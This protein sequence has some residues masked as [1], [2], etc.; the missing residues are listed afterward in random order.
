MK[1]NKIQIQSL[2]GK[3]KAVCEARRITVDASVPGDVYRDLL[4][5]GKIPD[6][7]YRDNEESLQWIGEVD[8]V[9]SRTFVVSGEM[10]RNRCLVLRCEGLDTLAEVSINGHHVAGTDNMFRTYE[11]DV[12]RLLSVGRNTI[13]I[14]FASVLPYIRRH[15]EK[16]PNWRSDDYKAAYPGW[17]RKEQCNFG[18]DWGIKAVTCGI[19]R[20]I[21][22]IAYDHARLGDVHIRQHHAPGRVV[23]DVDVQAQA[24]GKGI[25]AEATILEGQAVVAVSG[26]NIVRNQGRLRLTIKQPKLWWPN[27]M[28]A[29]PLY[30]VRVDLK[31]DNGDLVDTIEKR[32][33]LR[34]LT[35][36]RH[37][38]EWGESFQFVVNGVPFFAKGANWIPVD[39]IQAR[40]TPERYRRLVA[41]AAAANMNMLRVWGGGIYEDDS[42]YDACDELGICVWQDFMFA[43]AAYPTFLKGF[44]DNI[45]QEV[46]DSI[47]RLRHH[48]CMAL[49]CGNNELEMMNVGDAG[50]KEGVMPWKDYKAVFDDLLPGLVGKHSPDIPYWPSSPHSPRGDRREHRSPL[51][52]DA[53][54]W[55]MCGKEPLECARTMMH[56]FASEFGFQSF[57]E[58]RTVNGYTEVGDRNIDSRIMELHQRAPS[59]NRALIATILKCFRMPVGFENTLWLSQI[60]QGAAV[61][62]ACEHFRRNMPRSMGALYWQLNDTW[63]VASWSSIDCHGRW[64]ALHYMARHFFAPLIVS[65]VEDVSRGTVEIHVTSDLLEAVSA[66]V[67]WTVTDIDGKPLQEGKRKLRAAACSSRRVQ[68]L[69]LLELTEQQR[70]HG[71]LVWLELEAAGQPV[72]RSLVLF[73][74]PKFLELDKKPGIAAKIARKAGGMF[75]VT[76]ATRR[77][78]LWAWIEI[79]GVD[80]RLSDNFV[81]LRPG[82]PLVITVQPAHVMKLDEFRKKLRVRSLVDTY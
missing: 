70:N 59:G 81:H 1:T 53:H 13:R 64:K 67:K 27:R 4:D 79:G 22:L 41:D 69:N 51:S 24:V 36:D 23:L 78:A 16:F 25:R 48:P 62:G 19:W 35:L 21:S 60:L 50:W 29:Q 65:G 33:G 10:M 26:G 7:F 55:I 17:V 74:R 75:E 46:V 63:P 34:T 15:Q 44:K 56:R 12:K 45:R 58:P 32:I 3:W 42:F 18:W 40:A 2:S 20:P 30:T 31:N 66:S 61:R 57:P 37:D 5:T 71:V 72:S 43:C 9:Y 68:E 11:W 47:R 14:K 54:L 73:A 52:G 8:W 39:A 82:V 38:D 28:G 80:A 6:P 77:P 76:L 49:W